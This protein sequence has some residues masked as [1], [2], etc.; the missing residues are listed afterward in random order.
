MSLKL[1]KLL[2]FLVVLSLFLVA[3]NGAAQST[4]IPQNINPPTNTSAPEPP[5][6]EPAPVA[7]QPEP[8]VDPKT[9]RLGGW[10]DKIIFSAIPDPE[11][12][13]AQIQAGAIDM[14]SAAIDEAD[15]YEKVKADP[16]LSS[17]KIY[18]TSNQILFNTV[19]APIKLSSTP[20]RY[21]TARGDE[22]GS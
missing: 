20:S 14:Y 12:A 22:L 9:T 16:N 4:E 18:G 11:P 7:T 13:V 15:V 8:V 3:C 6:S 1:M 17:A 2:S 21:E 5:T 19:P 10:L